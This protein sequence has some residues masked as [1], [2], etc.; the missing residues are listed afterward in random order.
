MTFKALLAAG[1]GLMTLS[2]CVAVSDLGATGLAENI[3][4]NATTL[5]EAHARAMTAIISVNI[6]RSRDRWPTSYT[7]LSGI[8]SNPTMSM[9]GNAGFSPLGIGNA[10]MPFSDSSIGVSRSEAANAEYSINPFANNDKTQSLLRPVGAEMMQNYWNAGWPAD[11]LMWL[12]IDSVKFAGASEFW[13]ANGDEIAGRKTEELEPG[14]QEYMKL[15][16][17]ARDKDVRLSQLSGIN[18]DERNCTP[19]DPVYLRETLAGDPAQTGETMADMIAVVEQLTGKKLILAKDDRKKKAAN[20]AQI[21]PDKFE[22]RLLLCDSATSRWGF[23]DRDGKEVAEIR[24]RS[25]DDMVYFLGETMRQDP[26]KQVAKI[27]NV[28]FFRVYTQRDNRKFAV[29]VRH[30]D[31]VYFVAPQAPE[32]SQGT[33]WDQTG[34]VL[35]LLNQLYLYAQSDEFLRA[36]EAR[37]R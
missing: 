30:A 2:G 9:S 10:P 29:R 3:E 22:R 37:Y 8:R 24:T 36:P 14:A 21:A 1:A 11:T 15:I 34:N 17:R 7:T 4:S 28:E 25:F 23:V 13:F 19:Y 16:L 27:S 20:E 31:D 12:F 6:L 26:A 33:E 18:Q 35:G 32:D 5:N